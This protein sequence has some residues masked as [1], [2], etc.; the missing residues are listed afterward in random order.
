MKRVFALL[1]LGAFLLIASPALA[2][3]C[4]LQFAASPSADGSSVCVTGAGK[5][6]LRLRGGADEQSAERA[7]TVAEK[8]NQVAMAGA[9]P[10]DVAVKTSGKQAQI[11]IADRSIITIDA[12]LAASSKSSPAALAQAWA[13]NLK[14]VFDRPYLTLAP[15]GELLV[16]VGETRLLKWGG[17]LGKPEAGKIADEAVA[18]AQMV[19]QEKAFAV[20]ALQPGTTELVVTAPNCNHTVTLVCK[21]WAAQIPPSSQ[22]QISGGT[23]RRDSL[24][25]A[26]ESLVRNV[27]KVEPNA[28][29]N[30]GEPVP[31]SGGY[32]L[33]V[34]AWGDGYLPLARLHRVEL[35]R[36]APPEL[37]ADVLLVSNF[38]EKVTEPAVLLREAM[39]E[40]RSSRLLWH[41]VNLAD[42]PL[43]MAVLL[44]NLEDA[45]VR[46]HFTGAQAGPT[47]DEIFAGHVAATRFLS[48]LF[49]GTGY[50]LTIPARTSIEL[51]AVK[52][53]PSELGSGLARLAPLDPAR[54]MVEVV[55]ERRDTAGGLF[56]P[57]PK[58]LY[59]SPNT[60][61]FEFSGERT[62]DLQH[63]VGGGWGFYSLGKGIDVS[64]S[65]RQLPGSYGVLHRINAVVDNPTDRPAVVE[66]VT[67]PRGG[68]AR[69]TFWID[70]KL[71][72]TP[73]LTNAS[74]QVIY[75]AVV[76]A[77]SQYKL[78]VATTPQ[79]G[80]H[81]PMLLTL[82]S[83]PK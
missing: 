80:S 22:L 83:W 62:V 51:S 7:R 82:R 61:G 72:E 5:V 63:T 53:R 15:F 13:Q 50:V 60:S 1:A 43:W 52:L 16:P 65:G 39:A 46:V 11:V 24:L 23:L 54:L 64:A 4:V 25:Q 45:Q 41:H 28:Q 73:V 34:E 78:Q 74:E 10:D 9:G 67:R 79:S 32:Q 2:A 19:P 57:V 47:A 31:L 26:L 58:S 33:R 69:G 68:V 17:T 42:Y 81:Y 36:I 71:I 59:N 20:W 37:T 18:T 35:Q 48:D 56:S 38:P 6:L 8:L 14:A 27:T 44:H 49:F 40:G 29:L 77:K 76:D 66:L 70:G 75:R 3:D 55:C 21:K 30:C 12:A